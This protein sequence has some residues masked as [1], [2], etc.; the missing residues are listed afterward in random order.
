MEEDTVIAQIES[1]FSGVPRPEKEAITRCMCEECQEIRNDFSTNDPHELDPSRMRY[2]SW[3]MTFL[4]PVARHYFLPR[5]MILGIR[6]PEMAYADASIETLCYEDGWDV[7]GGYSLEQKK[8]IIDFLRFI[9]HRNGDRHDEDLEAAWEN[10]IDPEVEYEE[11]SEQAVPSDGPKPS[12]S[13]PTT[14]T[15]AP[16][17]AH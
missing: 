16:A 5:W 10:W 1:A 7:P 8:A 14:G 11:E 17:D 3:D 2:H 4:T 13:I 9:R 15:T 6:Q 12:N